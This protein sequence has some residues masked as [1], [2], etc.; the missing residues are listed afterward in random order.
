MPESKRVT[1]IGSALVD[2]LINESDAF[3]KSLNKEKG[4]M[5]LEDNQTIESILSQTDK[6]PVIVSGG[7]A[8]NT[9]V[10]IGKLGGDA[11]FIGRRGDDA[12][13]RLFEDELNVC[14]VESCLTL[15]ENPTGKVLS[16]VTPDAQRSMFTF[17]G[18][19]TEL[20][21]DKIT[22]ELFADTA[23]TMIEGYLL[24]NPE[25]MNAAVDAAKAA[26][27]KIALD[28][29]SFE[30]VNAS[31][32]L[33]DTLIKESVDILIANEDEAR[34]FTGYEDEA[35]ALER[36]AL[37]V[38]YG[39]LK[40]GKRGSMISHRGEVHKIPAVEGKDAVD[41][42]GAGDLWAAGFLYGLVNGFDIEKCG[43]IASACGYEVCQVMGAQIP[44]AGWER[45][46]KHI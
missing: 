16:V 7:A 46:R 33:L 28:L 4:G 30:V 17:L 14:S 13:G 29:A 9:I 42:T 18:A 41:T 27:S 31:K 5:T 25:L 2:I 24:F 6:T 35:N 45:I 34:A 32:D 12:Y 44:E 22:P 19:S 36:L 11:R 10:G 38:E 15:S 21:P 39:V 37:D 20:S 8:C 23:I 3:L 1:G 40:I 26:G 43:R